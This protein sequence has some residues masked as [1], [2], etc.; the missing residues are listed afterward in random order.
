MRST[1]IVEAEIWCKL[2]VGAEH[3]RGTLAS[4][5]VGGRDASAIVLAWGASGCAEVNIVLARGRDSRLAGTVVRRRN[6][7]GTCVASLAWK[8]GAAIVNGQR[9]D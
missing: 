9:N 1:R 2:A 8:R 4:V 6:I 5:V 3:A 7:V